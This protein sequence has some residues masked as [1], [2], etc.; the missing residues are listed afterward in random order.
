MEPQR[1]PKA[2]DGPVADKVHKLVRANVDSAHGFRE[3]AKLVK[4]SDLTSWFSSLADQRSASAQELR[5]WLGDRTDAD[6][7]GS[8]AAT[9]HRLWM[10]LRARLSG[11]DAYPILVEIQRGEGFI[12]EA[13]E[14]VL[15]LINDEP[16]K[17]QL[18]R[19]YEEIS[20]TDDKLFQLVQTHASQG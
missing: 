20:V 8:V 10:D 5:Q 7:R 13:Y 6:D 12:K 18:Q 17:T 4:D 11:G 14:L 3:A 16:L 2:S 15:R 19:Q 1:T 9:T